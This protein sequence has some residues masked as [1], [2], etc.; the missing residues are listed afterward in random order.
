MFSRHLFS[1]YVAAAL[2]LASLAANAQTVN[3][4]AF[5]ILPALPLTGSLS[6]ENYSLPV[7]GTANG[8]GG[9]MSTPW[10]QLCPK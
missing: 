9:C 3:L 7:T 10:L 5:P 4:G 8:R 6:P 2:V 1:G